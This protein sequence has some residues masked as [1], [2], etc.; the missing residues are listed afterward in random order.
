MENKKFRLN[1]DNIDV[2]Q[3]MQ[4]IVY[5]NINTFNVM[6]DNFDSTQFIMN[7]DNYIR[8]HESFCTQN[9]RKCYYY[10][11]PDPMIN[12]Y[13]ISL[14]KNAYH[15]VIKINEPYA[16]CSKLGLQQANLMSGF[17]P[18]NVF[19]IQFEYNKD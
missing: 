6:K 14:T 8:L 12:K 10:D 16:T 13:I 5:I 9:S 17:V 7:C 4:H 3:L 15:L 1:K 11:I 2:V 19:N 18:I